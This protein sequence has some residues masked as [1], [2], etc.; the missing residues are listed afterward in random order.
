MKDKIWNFLAHLILILP[1]V[2]LPILIFSIGVFIGQKKAI[3]VDEIPII[4]PKKLYSQT[5][6]RVLLYDKTLT[7]TVINYTLTDANTEYA[8]TL[9]AGTVAFEIQPRDTSVNIKM[10]YYS[11]ESGTNYWT[12]RGSSGWYSFY[13][14]NYN[15]SGKTIYLQSSTAG[16]IV[17]IHIIKKP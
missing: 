10:G 1:I 13:L 5:F 11:G 14:P 3:E 17:E 2:L 9:P 7:D 12:I 16:A 8:I 6:P 15:Y 4:Q